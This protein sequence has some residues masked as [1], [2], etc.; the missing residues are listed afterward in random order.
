MGDVAK[1]WWTN[2]EQT[3]AGKPSVDGAP[4]AEGKVED[5]VQGALFLALY[6]YFEKSGSVYKLMFGP[7]AF[8]IVSDP[9]VARH[10]LKENSFGYD[11]G[12]LAEIL[13][14]IMGKGLIPAD[15]ETWKMR[16]RAIVPG[17]HRAWLN[18]MVQ[19]FNDCTNVLVD[20]LDET[21]HQKGKTVD[22][23]AAFCSL[24]LDII[25]LSVFNYDFGSVTKESP[26][27]KAV[28]NTLREAEHRS[29]FYFPYWH[30]PGASWIVPRQRRFQADLKLINDCLDDLIKHAQRTRREEELE[31]L[32]KKDYTNITDPSL[33]RFLV[34]L[35][36]EQVTNKQLRDDLMTMLVAGHETTAALLTWALFCLMTHP[37]AMAKA[38]EEID[39]VLG[40][41]DPTYELVF[42]LEYVRLVL[43]E[44]LRLY[45]E[46]PIL[47]RRA[48]EDDLLPEGGSNQ[49]IRLLKGTDVFISVWNLH[50]SP[51]LWNSPQEFRP[52]RFNEP[53]SN[54]GVQGWAGYRPDLNGQ[55]YPNEVASD[56]AFIP[57]GGGSRKCIGDQFAM[58][59]ATVALSMLLRDFSF[60]LACSPEEVGIQ[61]G[62]TIHT[63]NGLPT[64]V[65]RRNAVGK[66]VTD[67][68]QE[69]TIS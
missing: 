43:A 64:I 18:R 21:S 8:I 53:H 36:G 55:L 47:I 17:L 65:K 19:L 29:T 51:E 27:I 30:I 44:A 35:R 52:E 13:E 50:R 7:K 11:K 20:Q 3:Y 6:D 37:E 69:T 68:I 58:L 33:L 24:G 66:P 61:T 26:V 10:I 45:P 4:V 67:T 2:I 23:E 34:D 31:D 14:P 56:F 32:E 62:A 39:R 60:E 25:G 49:R 38:Q 15:Y 12:V 40:Q 48:L 9:V 5:L 41:K 28:Y 54:P 63:A 57:F 59:E 1:I 42:E 46:P 22:M 16:R